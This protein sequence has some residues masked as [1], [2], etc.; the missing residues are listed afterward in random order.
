MRKCQELATVLAT[1]YAEN[2]KNKQFPKLMLSHKNRESESFFAT[3]AAGK[4]SIDASSLLAQSYAISHLGTAIKAGHLADFIGESTPRFPLRPLWLKASTEVYL[5]EN[6]SLHLPDFML[7]E[8]ARLLIPR[9]CKRLI[10]CGFNAILIG[11]QQSGWKSP[12]SHIP[13]KSNTHLSDIFQQLND[14]AIKILIKPH[15]HLDLATAY[16]SSTQLHDRLQD[17]I[18]S[19]FKLFPKFEALFWE[20]LCATPAYRNGAEAVDAIDAEIVLSEIRLLEQIL[21]NRS[22]LIFYMPA[23]QQNEGL[24]QARL[25]THLIDD[26]GKNSVLAF[27]AVCGEFFDDHSGDHPLWE[28]LRASPDSSATALLPLLNIGLLKQGEGLWPITNFDLLERFLSRCYRHHFAGIIGMTSHIPEPGSLLDCNLWVAGQALWRMLP[29][30]LLAETWFKAFRQKED[31]HFFL[32]AMKTARSISL[33]LS[34]LR[35]IASNLA[36]TPLGIEEAKIYGENILAA[37]KRLKF[38]YEKQKNPKKDTRPSTKDHFPFFAHD[39]RQLLGS[40]LPTFNLPLA[41]I[42]DVEEPD[43]SFWSHELEKPHR[44]HKGSIMEAIY[45]ENRYL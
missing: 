28:L 41:H 24:R 37:L 25:I 34:R 21:Q 20:S 8:D 2:S 32:T 31:P 1:E 4:L 26:M 16:P 6:I 3:Y 35:S 13:T 19:L 39:V 45:L 22:K 10:E 42:F 23:V 43:I 44:G 38:L 18:E 15:F 14:H 29:P 30:S 12:I 9:F 17:S 27:N 33:E 40:F 36:H 5:A 11:N 7:A